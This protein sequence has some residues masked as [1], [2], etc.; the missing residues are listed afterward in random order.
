MENL[1]GV[2]LLPGTGKLDGFSRHRA[3]AQGRAAARVA[4]Q[5]G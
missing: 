3:D 2:E 4:V 5:L 1:D